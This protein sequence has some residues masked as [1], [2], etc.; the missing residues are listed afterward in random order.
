MGKKKKEK[1]HILEY[2]FTFLVIITINFALP[3]M[4][5]GDP[6]LHLAGDTD[7]VITEFSMVQLE[8]Y[9]EYYGLDLPIYVQYGNYLKELATGNLGYS[10]YYKEDVSNIILRRLPWTLF[11]AVSSLMLSL[12]MGVILGSYSAFNR[13]KW[14]DKFLYTSLTA[15]SR[16]P[17]FLVGLA[18]LVVF[19]RN[20]D[21]LPL[22]G[23]KS[24]FVTYNNIFEQ[25]W[26]VIS[27]A[28]LPVATL[29]ISRVGGVYLLVRNSLSTVLTKDYIQT[30]KAKGLSDYK[31]KYIHALKNAL[32][33]IIT[34]V[35]AQIGGLVGGAVL[36]ENVFSYPGLG[37][38]MRSA[39][40]VRDYPLLQGVFLVMAFSVIFANILADFMYKKIDPRVAK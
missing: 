33:P 2:I 24:H 29:A 38:L 40:T 5:P 7:E 35:A 25:A 34:R 36:A 19:G 11:L 18:L 22:A 1:R 39:V 14:Q 8:Y 27:H 26:D 15:F 28:I 20:L 3:R 16:I 10:Y 23:A 13:D 6:F 31:I 17:A 21:W 12:V 37:T 30:A 4:M 9:R 32:L